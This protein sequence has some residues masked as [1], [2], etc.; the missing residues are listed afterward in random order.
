MRRRAIGIPAST[1]TVV[2]A[3]TAACALVLSGPPAAATQQLDWPALAQLLLD[4]LALQPGERV[5]VVGRPGR[6]DALIERVRELVVTTGA[7]DLGALSVTAPQP[8]AWNTPFTLGA[9]GVEGASLVGYLESVDVALMFPGALPADAPYAA[10]QAVLRSG[11]GRTVHFH[12]EGAYDTNG[13][14]LTVDAGIDATYQRVLLQTDYAALTTAQRQFEAALRSDLI[15]VTTPLGTDVR[16]RI[17]DRPVTRQD[18]DASAARALQARNLIDREVELPAGAI[19]VAPLE[20]T[21]E[22]TIAFP[23]SSWAGEPVE[24]LVMRFIAGELVDWSARSG[25]AAVA[26]ELEYGGATARA[27]RE[28]AVGLNPLL[29][30]PAQA[31]W[32]PYYGYGAGI[33]RLSLGDNTELGGNVTGGYVRWNFFIDATLTIGDRIWIRDGAWMGPAAGGQGD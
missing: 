12:W 23:P 18:G 16:F 28:L 24:G 4:R 13:N 30:I 8:T 3:I 25:E 7:E 6:F 22:G 2:L 21:V 5:L 32:I 11:R 33:V 14:P 17:G 20:D 19:R 15:R 27:F 31:P 10:M 9:A 1:F 26:R 29:V